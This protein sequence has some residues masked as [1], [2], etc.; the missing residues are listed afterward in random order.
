VPVN[1]HGESVNSHAV[2]TEGNLFMLPRFSACALAGAVACLGLWVHIQFWIPNGWWALLYLALFLPIGLIAVSGVAIGFLAVTMSVSDA[3]LKH[4]YLPGMWR[5]EWLARILMVAG[6]IG[7]MIWSYY[8]DVVPDTETFGTSAVEQL[9]MFHVFYFTGVGVMHFLLSWLYMLMSRKEALDTFLVQKELAEKRAERRKTQGN[10]AESDDLDDAAKKYPARDMPR[11]EYNLSRVWGMAE[12]KRRLLN[13]VDRFETEGGNGLLLYGE[14]GTGKT[15]LVE[16][17]AGELGYSLLE[18]RATELVSRWV[19]QTTEQVALIRDAALIQAPCVLFFDEIDSLLPKRESEMHQDQRQAVNAMLTTIAELNAR[20]AQHRVLVVAATNHIDLLDGAGIR[21][22]RF[23]VKVEV[24]PPDYEARLGMLEQA[25]GGVRYNRADLEA[26]ARRWEGFNV[27]RLQLVGRTAARLAKTENRKVDTDLLKRAL[28]DVQ[29]QSGSRLA[30]NAPDLDDLVFTEQASTQ[31]RSMV[32]MLREPEKIEAM[33]GRVPRGAIFYGPP[34]TGKTAV[35]QALAKETE[36]AFLPTSGQA[37]LAKP[38]EIDRLLEKARNLR[39]TIVFI[40][41]AES[42]LADRT[43]SPHS[44]DVTNKLLAQMDGPKP[45]H[46]VFFIAATNHPQ[47]LDE[48]MTRWGRFSEHVDFTPDES[49]VRELTRRFIEQHPAVR[50]HGDVAA[51]AARFPGISP[52]DLIGGLT[53]LISEQAVKA[54]G[55]GGKRQT[56]QVEIDLDAVEQ[57]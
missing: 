51:F 27:K 24:P 23:D 17:L 36:W 14:P 56:A 43:G 34:G 53:R 29:G 48:A 44:R 11:E 15:F 54:L 55:Q 13:A 49:V 37:L 38:E 40:D 33:G 22:G 26:S 18:A 47:M 10:K 25:L 1:L 2:F 42:V 41:E 28:R 19:G 8:G 12:T 4:Q 45:L 16:N 5:T 35:A 21:E 3:D 6:Y 31:L 46:D 30:E 50:W 7:M 57:L 20:F 32:M 52:A 39:P 9:I